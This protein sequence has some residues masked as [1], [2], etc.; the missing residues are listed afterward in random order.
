M[1][2]GTKIPTGAAGL[3]TAKLKH[4]RRQVT[5]DGKRLYTFDGDSGG[6]VTGNGVEGFMVATA[7]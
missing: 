6:D 5:F 3:A 1:P 2:K 4:H 7:P